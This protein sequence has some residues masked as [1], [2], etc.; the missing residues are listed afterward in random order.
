MSKTVQVNYEEMQNIIKNMKSEQAEV[1]TLLRQTKSKVESLHNN[2]WVGEAADKF[3]SE[4]EGTVLPALNR[5][6]NALGTA[7]DVAQKAVNTIQQADEGTKRFFTI[8]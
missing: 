5:L 1:A 4:M 6:E 8:S 7:A 2:Q 3:F